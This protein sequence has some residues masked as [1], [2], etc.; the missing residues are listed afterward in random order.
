MT[1]PA[2]DSQIQVFGGVDTHRDTHTAA[3]VD[4]AGAMLGARQFPATAAGYAALL[5]WLR[6]LGC[7]VR[8]GIEGTS[9]Y[10]A[11]LAAVFAAVGVR[12]AVR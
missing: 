10:G 1:A 8:V 7:L 2:T 5:A 12:G 6:S 11:G 4:A 3:A 9:S